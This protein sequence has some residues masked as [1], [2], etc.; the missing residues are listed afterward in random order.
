MGR[1]L[2]VAGFFARPP[3]PGQRDAARQADRFQ[4]PAVAGRQDAGAATA[5]LPR[6]RNEPSGDGA[7][8]RRRIQVER[9]GRR[10]RRLDVLPFGRLV[11]RVVVGA[12]VVPVDTAQRAGDG[13][14][15]AG[16]EGV[17]PQQS[18]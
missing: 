18:G 7:L 17:H 1:C 8:L 4:H 10:G 15:V 14:T 11:V 9:E 12:A 16:P 3:Q 2:R 5:F 13:Q 6:F